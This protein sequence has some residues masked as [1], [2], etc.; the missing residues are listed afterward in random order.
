MNNVFG[1]LV[2]IILNYVFITDIYT[3]LNAVTNIYSVWCSHRLQNTCRHLTKIDERRHGEWDLKN[4]IQKKGLFSWQW[5]NII[6]HIRNIWE[7]EK[8]ISL[9]ISNCQDLIISYQQFLIVQIGHRH[10]NNN[11]FVSFCML[12]NFSSFEFC[13][14]WKLW[15]RLQWQWTLQICPLRLHVFSLEIHLWM[16]L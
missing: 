13:S 5:K 14:E 10:R 2:C 7:A 3:S 6:L 15:P 16:R 8:K 11:P 4:F 9:P 12:N 1:I